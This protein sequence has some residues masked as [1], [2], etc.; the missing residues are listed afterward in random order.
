AEQR[1]VFVEVPEQPLPSLL[2]GFSAPVKLSFPYIRDQ[3]LFLMQQDSD[4]LNR[5]EAGQQLSVQVLQ[6]LIGQHQRVAQL[7]LDPRLIEA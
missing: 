7:V 2:R 5:W 3:L 4:G 6:E 1:F